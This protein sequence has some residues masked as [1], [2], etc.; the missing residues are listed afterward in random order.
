M[1]IINQKDTSK[2]GL[3]ANHLAANKFGYFAGN[4]TD[5]LHN[6]YSIHTDPNV[7]LVDFNGSSNVRKESTLDEL[8][9]KAPVNPRATQY[10]SKSGRKYSD[11]G[12]TEGRY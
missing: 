9:P 11:L 6:Q 10:K 4:E 12:P 5:K 7:K 1:A 8:D 3:T 2:L